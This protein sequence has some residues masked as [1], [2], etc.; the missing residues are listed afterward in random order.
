[1]FKFA[2]LIVIFS[3]IT[4]SCF[5]QTEEATVVL[6][7]ESI[8]HTFWQEFDITFWQ[9]FPFGTLSGYFIERQLSNFMY[10]GSAVRWNAVF[11]FAAAVSA[12]N[13]YIHAQKVV[14]K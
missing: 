5:A 11:F 14:K 13:A 9:T 1:M 3:I 10:P 7:K 2:A 8:A 12:G 4:A 6:T